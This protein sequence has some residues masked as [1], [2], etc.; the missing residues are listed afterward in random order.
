MKN[1][2]DLV[3]EYEKELSRTVFGQ[4]TYDPKLKTLTATREDGRTLYEI[5]METIVHAEVL[6]DWIFQVTQKTW[7]TPQM[8]A[9]LLYAFNLLLNPQETLCGWAIRDAQDSSK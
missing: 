1:L 6:L 7:C 8:Q 5:D 4:W 2:A 3:A 9:D